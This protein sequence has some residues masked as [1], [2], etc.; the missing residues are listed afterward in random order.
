MLSVTFVV[1]DSLEKFRTIV[2]D[3]IKRYPVLNETFRFETFDDYLNK[4]GFLSEENKKALE[5]FEAN[6]SPACAF[7]DIDTIFITNYFWE[8]GIPDIVVLHELGHLVNKL[9][10]NDTTFLQGLAGEYLADKYLSELD[11][12]LINARFDDWYSKENQALKRLLE[13]LKKED[14]SD[15]CRVYYIIRYYEELKVNRKSLDELVNTVE[16]AFRKLGLGDG[17]IRKLNR[18]I[19]ATLTDCTEE[20]IN[21]LG[22]FYDHKIESPIL[23]SLVTFF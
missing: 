6:K 22:A 21:L 18:L 20:S 5:N 14:I 10:F 17:I 23:N 7:M 19:S 3:I 2:S 11:S 4:K 15:L 1:Y 13:E 16:S 12:E 9:Q 8:E